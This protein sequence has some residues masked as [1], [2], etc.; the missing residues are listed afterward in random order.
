MLGSCGK[1][2]SWGWTNYKIQQ[3]VILPLVEGRETLGVHC[4]S[5]LCQIL[6][7]YDHVKLRSEMFF[8]LCQNLHTTRR[9]DKSWDV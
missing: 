4:L 5:P 9:L 7:I 6:V 8:V 2:L 3:Y 1:E